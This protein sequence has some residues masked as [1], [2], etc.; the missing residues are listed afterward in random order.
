MDD[1]MRNDLIN[2][3]LEWSRGEGTQKRKVYSAL[4]WLYFGL[5]IE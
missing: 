4:L 1:K 5:Y 3:E 2:R